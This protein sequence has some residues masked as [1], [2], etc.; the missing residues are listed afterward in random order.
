MQSSEGTVP[1]K[2]F[3]GRNFNEILRSGIFKK[4]YDKHLHKCPITMHGNFG[5]PFVNPI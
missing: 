1:V 2:V 5:P 3:T 4:Y